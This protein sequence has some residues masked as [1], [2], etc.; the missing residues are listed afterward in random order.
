MASVVG[1]C[2]RCGGRT[3]GGWEGDAIRAEIRLLRDCHLSQELL[4]GDREDAEVHPAIVDFTEQ[5][6]H[7][8]WGGNCPCV[9]CRP[10]HDEFIHFLR[11]FLGFFTEEKDA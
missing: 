10:C 5:Q 9:L 2:S 1:A 8:L 7:I 11:E 6:A 3:V 4:G